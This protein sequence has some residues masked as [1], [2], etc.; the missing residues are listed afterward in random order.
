MVV[1]DMLSKK[2]HYDFI[3][4]FILVTSSQALRAFGQR[5]GL[6]LELRYD[7]PC[8]LRDLSKHTDIHPITLEYKIQTNLK[9]IS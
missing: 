3:L 5:T 6:L 7:R 8:R 4:L 1:A 9:E 2:R